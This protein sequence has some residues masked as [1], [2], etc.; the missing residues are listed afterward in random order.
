MYSDR[1]LLPK[2]RP[3]DELLVENLADELL[4]YD[5][6]T[7]RAH[8]LNRSAALVWSLCDGKATIGTLRAALEAEGLPTS[9]DV[10]ALGLGQLDKAGLLAEKPYLPGAAA[11]HSRREMLKKLGIA[12]GLAVALPLVQSIVAPSVA[13]AASACVPIGGRG[14]NKNN[15]CCAGGICVNGR[16]VG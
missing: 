4:V 3:R 8:C 13:Q 2:A 16:C 10:I 15:P 14:C 1:T 9:D 11:R 12:A 6:A 5:N 7:H